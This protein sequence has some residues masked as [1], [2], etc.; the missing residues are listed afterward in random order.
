[1]LTKINGYA[2]SFEEARYTSY[3]IKDDWFFKK[4]NKIW[5]LVTNSTKKRFVSETLYD[6]KY[7]KTKRK[8][9]KGKINTNF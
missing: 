8:S 1:M 7:L 3:L 5:D 6:K 4:C 9:H 2:K